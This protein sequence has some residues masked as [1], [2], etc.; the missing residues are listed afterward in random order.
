V[1]GAICGEQANRAGKFWEYAELAMNLDKH[2]GSADYNEL[3]RK[4]GV[5]PRKGRAEAE[6]VV[7]RDR[8]IAQKLKMRLTP[9]FIVLSPD[10]PARSTTNLDLTQVLAEPKILNY[11][12]SRQ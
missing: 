4:V 12:R 1:E 2:P 10:M 9:I 8:A 11:I 5:D 6:R 3:L 7:E